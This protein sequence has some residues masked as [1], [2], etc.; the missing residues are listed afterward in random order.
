M[1]LPELRD[2]SS[3]LG[4]SLDPGEITLLCPLVLGWLSILLVQELLKLMKELDH[5]QCTHRELYERG[6]ILAEAVPGTEHRWNDQ[7]QMRTSRAYPSPCSKDQACLEKPFP[8][9]SPQCPAPHSSPSSA[10][11]ATSVTRA[12]PPPPGRLSPQ[13]PLILK[14]GMMRY[15]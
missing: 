9:S 6:G 12:Q 8:T 10:I 3:N 13:W 4:S 14:S 2:L 5:L 1:G 11:T 15:T 7:E